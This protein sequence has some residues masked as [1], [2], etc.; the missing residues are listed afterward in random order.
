MTLLFSS[1]FRVK[2]D[3]WKTRHVQDG[4]ASDRCVQYVDG[5]MKLR[6]RKNR[7]G[8]VITGHVSTAEDFT[9][10]YGLAEARMKFMSPLG[11]HSAFWLQTTEDYI[12]GQAEIDVVEHFGRKNLWHNVYW[13]ESGQGAG[14]FSSAKFCT[15]GVDPTSWHVYGCE[16][17]ADGYR[18][19]VDGQETSFTQEGLSDRPKM[20]VL[21]I[22]SNDWERP[23]LQ[24]D[25]LWRYRTMVD[26]V[27]VTQ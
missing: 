8:E 24:L 2:D 18:F 19:F 22:L 4:E 7:D 25:A 13:R 17:S 5:R 3:R 27:K 10:T 20:L 16:W 12:P 15:Q 1:D 11:A 26:W 14:E 23:D 9:F 6:V 21:S